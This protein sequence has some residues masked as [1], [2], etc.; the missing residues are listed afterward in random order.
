[1]EHL[2]ALFAAGADGSIWSLTISHVGSREDMATYIS[3]ALEQERK[4]TGMPFTT[5]VKNEKG[6]IIVGST[7]FFNIEPAHKRLEIGHTWITPEWQ[8]TF[9]N[10]DAKYLMLEY[11]FETLSVNRVEFKTDALNIASRNALKRLGAAEEGILRR[12]SI[13]ETGRVRDTVYFSIIEEEW[14]RVKRDI[15]QKMKRP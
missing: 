5:M 1:M 2:D 8:R 6:N 9:V 12:H 4:G 10:T 15:E 13:T 11:A 14:P 3:S 7:R